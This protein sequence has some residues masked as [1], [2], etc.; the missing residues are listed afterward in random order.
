[1]D[2]PNKYI[3]VDQPNKEDT[4][5]E[6]V[7]LDEQMDEQIY[8]SADN[9]DKNDDD[10]LKI[11]KEDESIDLEAEDINEEVIQQEEP[12][13]NPSKKED[14]DKL[15][16]FYYLKSK[17]EM[18]KHERCN[19][20]ILID[21][22]TSIKKKRWQ[23]ARCKPKCINCKRSVGSIFSIK[24]DQAGFRT[25]IAKCGDPAEPCPFN[26]E[27]QVPNVVRIDDEYIAS[28]EELLRVQEQT[29]IAKNKAVFGIIT[30]DDA[31]DMFD[32][33]K[34]EIDKHVILMEKN[35]NRLA[36]VTHNVEKQEEINKK[37][38]EFDENVSA[39]KVMMNNNND[40]QSN[41][42]SEFYA[43]VL[44]QSAFELSK[45]KFAHR[46]VT[47]DGLNVY[48]TFEYLP[49]ALEVQGEIKI[50]SFNMG[51]VDSN[52]PEPIVSEPE[53]SAT[54]KKA[55][56]T[57]RTSPKNKTV[58]KT[59]TKDITH[60]LDE[61]FQTLVIEDTLSSI[62]PSQLYKFIEDT[63]KIADVRDNYRSIIKNYL[64]VKLEE[65][66]RVKVEIVDVVYDMMNR[67]INR[68]RVIEELK[69]NAP[70]DT[71]AIQYD[72]KY[73]RIIAEVLRRYDILL[74][75]VPDTSAKPKPEW[76]Q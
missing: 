26:I 10:I 28:N 29:I 49:D 59:A 68:D 52:P 27:M 13:S 44:V 41:P 21:K 18:D 23:F 51:T 60:I 63:Y 53:V 31:V 16:T 9:N 11:G 76:P 72:K 40:D 42:A 43:N 71:V 35:I 61:V 69:L 7:V 32:Q 5:T 57:N 25:F 56:R 73:K 50:I 3:S 12:N 47:I 54:K 2:P 24:S 46:E 37:I 58:R 8:E 38:A 70:V 30:P 55:T 45:L 22:T 33:L 62:K 1:M 34:T 66:K 17:Y 20:K 39:F 64:S 14:I 19:Q 74:E 67:G 15:Q 6:P 75:S 65:W 4:P 36:E 48:E